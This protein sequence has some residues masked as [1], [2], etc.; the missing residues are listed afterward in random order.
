MQKLNCEDVQQLV[1]AFDD[2]ELEGVT[3]LQ[4]QQHL[5]TCPSC[6]S[7]RAWRQEV[8]QALHRIRE[9]S[10]GAGPALRQRVSALRSGGK[11]RRIT[12]A[13]P[14]ALSA[15]AMLALALI[16][17]FFVLPQTG[18]SGGDARVFV[19]NHRSIIFDE[20]PM[21]I[22]TSDPEEAALWLAGQ[23]PGAAS[24][25]HIPAGYRL[26]GAR[27]LDIEGRPTGLLLYERDGRK[28]SCFVRPDTSPV[29]RG[30]DEVV[31]RRDDLKA[32]R[33]RG[34]QIVTWA[35]AGGSIVVIG[36]LNE[37]SLLTFAEQQR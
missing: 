32:G 16:L 9:K 15:A 18:H 29:T 10:P 20:S 5:E 2:H 4:V 22:E 7:H 26:T 6:R 13:R 8:G 23:L 14:F 28:I 11:R 31:L 37:T 12:T 30:F 34:H 27:V 35:D 24:P 1:D 17:S 25:R 3:S 21:E 19:Q 33:C 36:D